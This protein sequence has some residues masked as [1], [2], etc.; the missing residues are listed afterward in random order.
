[1]TNHRL[2]ELQYQTQQPRL[3]AEAKVKL[4]MKTRERME[5]AVADDEKYEVILSA[6][7]ND[8]PMRWTSFSDEECTKPPVAPEKVS[9][10]IWSTKAPKRQSQIYNPW[11]CLCQ[12]PP[13]SAAGGL[14]LAGRASTTLGIV[15]HPHPLPWSFWEKNKKEQ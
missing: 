8:D 6:W 9:V 13:P 7:V 2:E 4:D 1:M 3:P 10:T 12:H 5:G 15:F 11:R 14:L